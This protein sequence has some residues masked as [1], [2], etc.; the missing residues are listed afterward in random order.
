MGKKTNMTVPSGWSGQ[1]RRFAES[2]K[3]SVDC[4]VGSRGNPLDKAVTY[5]DLLDSGLAVLAFGSANFSGDPTNLTAPPVDNTNP[6]FRIPP[7]PTNLEANGA[8]QNILLKWDL[9][10][11][12][13]HSATEIYRHTSDS[14]TDATL[15][16]RASGTIFSDSVGGGKTFYYWVRAVNQNGVFG[17]YNSSAGTLGITQQDVQMILDIL[18]DQIT[19]D[20]LTQDLLAPITLISAEASVIGSVAYQLAQE[21]EARAVALLAE[22]TARATAIGVETTD[23]IAAITAE[24]SARASAAVTLQSQI[25]DL[26]DIAPYDASVSYAVGDQVT[27]DDKLYKALQATLGNLPT[28]ASYWDLLGTYT[29]L[30]DLVGSNLASITAINTVSATSSSAAAQAIQGLESI[31]NDPETG[32][33]ASSSAIDSVRTLVDHSETGVTASAD[34]ITALESTVDDPVTGMTATSGAL[35]VIETAVNH[36]DT[37]LSAVSGKVTA[38]ESTINGDS[39]ATPPVL[40]VATAVETLDSAVNHSDTGLSAV[41]G[42]VTALEA[43]ING[44]TSAVPPIIGVSSAVE[45]LNASVTD[46][47]TGLEATADKVEALEATVDDG[48]TGVVATAG[49]LETVEVLVNHSD[50]GV[51]ASANKIS[52]LTVTLEGDPEAN[53]PVSGLSSNFTELNN[54]VTDGE[55]GLEATADLV[56]GLVVLVGNA[57][58]GLIQSTTATAQESGATAEDIDSL[59]AFLNEANGENHTSL[60]AAITNERAVRVDVEGSFAESFEGVGTSLQGK[61]KTFFQ[62]DVPTSVAVGDLWIS[63]LEDNKLYRATIVEA[64]EIAA[65]EWVAVGD[66]TV[67]STTFAQDEIPTSGAVGD[68]WIDTDDKNTV[69]RAESVGADEV[70]ANEWVMLDLGKALATAGAFETLESEVYGDG[71]SAGASRLTSVFAELDDPA[72]GSTLLAQQIT[73][74][75]SEVFGIGAARSSRIDGLGV[76]VASKPDTF[77][78]DS[79]PVAT[80][81]GDLWIDTTAGNNNKLYR[82]SSVDPQNWVAVND[83]TPTTQTFIS[84]TVPTATNTGDLWVNTELTDPS[85]PSGEDNKPKNR[86]YRAES[87]DANEIAAGEWVFVDLGQAVSTADVVNSIVTEVFPTGGSAASSISQISARL[88]DLNGDETGVTLE[89]R[90]EAIAE[91]SE[92]LGGQYSV[93]ID[94]DGHVAGFGISNTIVNGVQES[95]FIVAADKF[96]IVGTG[97]TEAPLGTT[98]PDEVHVPFSVQPYQEP[99]ASNGNIEILAGVYM[100]SAFIANGSITTA[101]IGTATIHTANITGELTADHIGVNTIAAESIDADMLKIDGSTITSVLVNGVPTL[102]LGDVNVNKLTGDEIS[103]TIMSGTSVFANKLTGDVNT[104]IPFRSF[105]NQAYGGSETTMIE[106]DLP[107]SSH[108]LGHKPFAMCTG[109]MEPRFERVYRFKMYMKTAI[110]VV[111]SLGQPSA[112]VFNFYGPG[113]GSIQYLQ[114]SGDISGLVAIGQVLKNYMAVKTGTVTNVSVA[115]GVT[116]IYY[117]GDVFTTSDTITTTT[118]TDY[119]LVGETRTKS[120]TATRLMFSLTGSKSVPDTGVVGMKVTVT[121]MNSQ[122][123][124]EDSTTSQV[125]INEVSGMIMGVR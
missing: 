45:T 47:E 33:S 91:D 79:Q 113:Y 84:A 97:S 3:E 43:T 42:K 121:Q 49:A 83:T 119:T 29:S 106:V 75:E 108:P 94:A 111:N 6:I 39:D 27:Y 90:F 38:L 78:Q 15:I 110:A 56:E 118:S 1:D 55:H 76:S 37:G 4:L 9:E 17:P 124:S 85:L 36:S 71:G 44:D 63:T 25:N 72:T 34:K 11:Y 73:E 66:T 86:L 64:N 102:Q 70:T 18:T 122:D 13:G 32:V 8:F 116:T 120:R 22:S 67:T 58:S 115:S 74:I 57:S 68:L 82:A 117:S 26:L 123:V 92:N 125:T 69:Y 105:A 104:L 61:T 51:T 59:V 52:A 46:S 98:E 53:P 62:D 14:I 88:N 35:E 103:A 7:A 31:V 30:G 99:N 41:S 2:L 81:I 109:Y 48:E 19:S 16:G 114:Y 96:A 12:I 20:Q 40:G 87:S 28:D 21:A 89:E 54:A 93:K 77:A 24:A 50:T 23:R 65:G 107:A 100:K 60:A 101:Q 5:Q 95:A 80:A 10:D 112:A